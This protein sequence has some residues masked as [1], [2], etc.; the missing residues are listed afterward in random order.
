MSPRILLAA[1]LLAAL[2]GTPKPV[3]GADPKLTV[4][5]EQVTL[6]EAAALLERESGVPV[7]VALLRAPGIP[8][9]EVDPDQRMTFDWSRATLGRAL[10][11]L[12]DRYGLHLSSRM[13]GGYRLSTWLGSSR[14]QRYQLAGAVERSGFRIGVRVLSVQRQRAAVVSGNLMLDLWAESTGGDVEAI[15]GI[16]NVAA[17]DSRGGILV[18]SGGTSTASLLPDAWGS[19]FQ[20]DPPDPRARSLGWI[21]GDLVLFRRLRPLDIEAPLPLPEGGVQQRAGDVEIE[22]QRILPGRAEVRDD[23]IERQD[24]G[25]TVH[26]R[27]RYPLEVTLQSAGVGGEP[28]PLLV[29]RS[30]RTYAPRGVRFTRRGDLDAAV[31]ADYTYQFPAI[32]EPLAAVRFHLM[33]KEAPDRRL[34]FR[35]A[36]LP[37]PLEDRPAPED[38]QQAPGAAAFGPASRYFSQ[39]GGELVS[40]VVVDHRRRLPGT[41][42][43]GL[44]SAS[45]GAEA[46]SEWFQVEVGPDGTARLRHLLPGTYRVLRIYRP[47]EASR[48]PAGW[49][50]HGEAR[51]T[52]A[53][54]K[55]ALLPPLEW[56]PAGRAAPVPAPAAPRAAPAAAPPASR[57]AL[58]H[59]SLQRQV[60]VQYFKVPEVQASHSLQLTVSGSLDPERAG[61]LYGLRNAVAKDD[62]GNL[63]VRGHSS[64]SE[65]GQRWSARLTLPVPHPDA[66]KL[67]WLEVDLVA[68]RRRDP[69]TVEFP[70][71]AVRGESRKSVG[72]VRFEL[73][74]V[75]TGEAALPAGP[76]GPSA[77]RGF[78]VRASIRAPEL[79]RLQAPSGGAMQPVLVGASGRVYRSIRSRNGLE[80]GGRGVIADFACDYPAIDEP[81]TKVRIEVE[82]LHEPERLYSFRLT[83]LA[84]PPER[85]FLPADRRAPPRAADRDAGG[86]LGPEHPLYDARGG[87]LVTPIV[88][89]GTPAPAG[90]LLVGLAPAGSAPIRWVEVEVGEDGTATL[91]SLKPGAYVVRRT[92][93]PFEPPSVSGAGSWRGE[94]VRV[95][96]APGR[97]LTL[98]P[99]QWS[100]DPPPK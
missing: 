11:D 31:D 9:P 95:Q 21:E 6:A 22:V 72:P 10:E 37:L 76:D 81:V 25:P 70:L 47:A 40:R 58:D 20:L 75:S 27:I 79:T 35:I 46:G 71:P 56:V 64:I 55:T 53:A 89:G 44:S 98:P 2:A 94:E 82:F 13:G 18:T 16:E 67:E 19:M 97:K 66:K 59:L 49:W 15:A 50:R 7:E 99:L 48:E 91:G 74:D 1:L 80:S 39:D 92:Y 32:D 26:A 87:A 88:I 51:I 5:A 54:G 68:F 65:R 86:P 73:H 41:L 85:H 3:R 42:S 36:N 30:G 38:A 100:L 4:R 83:D 93:R 14:R 90:L 45:P 8:A 34:P 61:R 52:V 24:A 63:L 69:I 43:I 12:A 84:L 29:G 77:G 62:A 57:I 78:S 96:V 60:T 23:P 28:A 17:R 33:R